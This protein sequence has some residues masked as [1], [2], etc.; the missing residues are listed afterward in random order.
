MSRQPRQVQSR[1]TRASAAS[2]DPATEV[3][4]SGNDSDVSVASQSTVVRGGKPSRSST[5]KKG[6]NGKKAASRNIEDVISR[7]QEVEPVT[8]QP[9]KSK[10]GKELMMR[11]MDEGEGLAVYED[12]VESE[13]EQIEQQSHSKRDKG[14]GRVLQELP[15]EQAP[16]AA[17][18]ASLSVPFSPKPLSSARRSP[19]PPST[20]G[21]P[22]E[23]KASPSP[24]SSDA[25]NHPPSSRPSAIRNSLN[26]QN[27]M[28]NERTIR[29]PLASTPTGSPSKRNVISGLQTS[30]PWTALDLDNIFAR[31]PSKDSDAENRDPGRLSFNEILDKARTGNVPSPEK[32]MNVEEWIKHN[33]RMAEEKLRGECERMV[34][35][36]EEAGQ[37]AM[38]SVEGIKCYDD[39]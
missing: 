8:K 12:A 14:K 4:D 9:A 26:L 23:T 36:F 28:T 10:K 39:E 1:S 37:R 24:Q 38:R 20:P 19:Q 29:I 11:N 32:S 27:T 3:N 7:D 25:E 2:I 17:T 15:I 35:V 34:G 5:V 31:S 21:L 6:K 16:R 30:Q 18:P 13:P 22:Q 33:A